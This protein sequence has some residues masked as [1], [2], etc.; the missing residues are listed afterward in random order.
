M[1][2][3]KKKNKN[4]TTMT[5]TKSNKNIKR[6]YDREEFRRNF[7]VWWISRQ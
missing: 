5:L 2:L 4:R 3:T 7:D 6:K 1:P